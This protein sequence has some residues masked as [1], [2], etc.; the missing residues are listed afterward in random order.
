MNKEVAELIWTVFSS[1]TD[2]VLDLLN[3]YVETWLKINYFHHIH[4]SFAVVPQM[5]P[6]ETSK[7]PIKPNHL[8]LL[9]AFSV[10]IWLERLAEGE[11]GVTVLQGSFVIMQGNQ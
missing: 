4:F 2:Q 10:M 5:S 3:L 7:K 8:F 9:L 6:K 1:I 11:L